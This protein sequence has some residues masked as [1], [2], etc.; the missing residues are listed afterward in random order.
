MCELSEIL[1]TDQ[2]PFFIRMMS[3][4]HTTSAYAWSVAIMYRLFLL[5]W[6]RKL[7][8]S[9]NL[10]YNY[11]QTFTMVRHA[12]WLCYI[13][14]DNVCV[15]TQLGKHTTLSKNVRV[16]GY[17]FTNMACHPPPSP[18]NSYSRPLRRYVRRT[19]TPWVQPISAYSLCTAH[20]PPYRFQRIMHH[21]APCRQGP[22]VWLSTGTNSTFRCKSTY[23]VIDNPLLTKAD[24][25]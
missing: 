9:Y 23:N 22:V 18:I 8:P 16:Y 25:K 14:W 12:I 3:T 7:T 5:F 19:K 24:A 20:I 2:L 6:K 11:I 13:I 4:E 21:P 15:F 10:I 17:L 1:I